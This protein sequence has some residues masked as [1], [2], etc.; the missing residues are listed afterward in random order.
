MAIKLVRDPAPPDRK[1]LEEMLAHQAKLRESTT[2]GVAEEQGRTF[3]NQVEGPS[4]GGGAGTPE[5]TTH[6]VPGLTTG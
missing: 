1:S 6:T 2:G 4:V 5:P 3:L